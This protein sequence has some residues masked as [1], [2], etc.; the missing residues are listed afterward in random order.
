MGLRVSVCPEGSSMLTPLLKC[1]W[2]V[3]E[4]PEIR[5]DSQAMAP[6][7]AADAVIDHLRANGYLR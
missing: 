2:I 4:S 3:P 7:R 1:Q 5:I 6:D